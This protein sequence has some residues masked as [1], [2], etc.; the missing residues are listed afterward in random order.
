WASGKI[1]TR[2]SD[3]LPSF[4]LKD[5]IFFA[6]LL[7]G[8]YACLSSLWLYRS[9][10]LSEWHD[11]LTD[12][13]KAVSYSALCLSAVTVLA[14]WQAISGMVLVGFWLT[15]IDL[16]FAVRLVK[17][18][19]LRHFRRR[20]LNQRRVLIAGVG[21]RGEQMAE[22]FEK[23]PELGYKLIG[24]I[25]NVR[26]PDVLG[27]LDRAAEI[28]AA[29][30]VDELI[31]TLPVKSFYEE[32]SDIVSLAEDQG[33]M[34]RIHSDLFN[35][36]VAHAVA[37]QFDGI[38]VLTLSTGPRITWMI[39]IKRVIDVIGSAMLIVLLSPMLAAIALAIRLTSAG[40][41]LFVQ[42]RVGYN[43]RRFRMYKFR[44][45]VV[46]AERRLAEIEHLNEAQGPVFKIRK[47]P[48]ITRI[49]GFLRKTSLDEL[50][51]LFNVLKGDLSL[52]GPRPM[53]VRDFERFDEFW[54]NRRFSVRPGITCIWQVSGRS[55]TTFEQWI[56]QDLDYID[57]WS[58]A[59]D[60]RILFKTIPAVIRGD[61]AM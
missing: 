51:Q 6:L 10:R 43:K 58:L 16:L 32:I 9:R 31:I 39:S 26:R 35:K 59:L 44:T 49:G 8:W 33:I 52:V 41:A 1:P 47:D 15:A 14:H 2:L 27:P 46:D 7:A 5:A 22:L 48:R 53:S 18:V 13:A 55:N 12:V 60:L 4:S 61:G 28:L 17:R 42:E 34:V 56:Q 40:P 19:V 29:N 30:V 3:A 50:P 57:N 36:R 45:M 11:E 24:F 38:P 21:P 20:G 25:D 54:F 23:Y 37:E